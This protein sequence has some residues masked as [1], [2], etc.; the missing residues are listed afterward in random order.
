[1]A[2][3]QLVEHYNNADTVEA[4]NTMRR[5]MSAKHRKQTKPT[6]SDLASAIQAILAST[7][8]TAK[9]KNAA[10]LALSTKPM[11]PDN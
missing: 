9:A 10:I 4:A 3:A 2:M 1:M 7:D 8:L 5:Q 11:L 6:S